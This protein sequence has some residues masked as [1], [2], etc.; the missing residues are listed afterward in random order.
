VQQ[1]DSAKDS[2]Y[3]KNSVY[4]M[5]KAQAENSDPQTKAANYLATITPGF[6]FS[7]TV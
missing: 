4:G 5:M 6:L 1:V 3:A 7:F 2:Q